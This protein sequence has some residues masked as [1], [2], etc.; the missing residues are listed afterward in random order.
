MCRNGQINLPKNLQSS[1]RDLVKL[2]L[3]DD[4]EQRLNIKQIKEHSF[5][6]SINWIKLFNRKI[7][8]PFVPEKLNL[9]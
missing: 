5:F 9:R 6:K 8:P 3:V 1:A 7:R 2:L 4:P